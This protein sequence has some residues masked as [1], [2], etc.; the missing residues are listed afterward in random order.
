MG[1]EE[2]LGRGDDAALLDDD[3]LQGP[4][5]GVRLLQLDLVHDVLAVDHLPEGGV[6]AVQPRG[7]DRGDEELAAAGVPACNTQP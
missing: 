5:P 4:V 3:R 6:L 2:G 1:D 7:G